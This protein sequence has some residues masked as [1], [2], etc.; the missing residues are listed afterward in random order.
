MSSALPTSVVGQKLPLR[1]QIRRLIDHEVPLRSQVGLGLGT[2][3]AHS[4]GMSTLRIGLGAALLLLGCTPINPAQNTFPQ[5]E[6]TQVAGPPGGQIDPGYGYQPPQ[7]QQDPVTYNAD[8][9]GYPQGYQQGYPDGSEAQPAEGYAPNGP[10]SVDQT[11]PAPSLEPSADPNDP[12]YDMGQVNDDEIDATLDG[13]G[14]WEESEDYGRVWVPDTTAVGVDFTPYETDGSWIWSD[15]GW[16]YQCD[17]SW[18]WLPF[19][20]GRW[21]WFDNHWGWQPG[22]QW[23]A[24]AVEWR[25]GGG[26]TGWRPLTPIIRDHRSGVNI[27]DHRTVT[28]SDSQWRFSANNEFGHGHI[29]GHLFQNPSEG[30]RVTNAVQRPNVRGNYAAVSSASLMRNR[31]SSN[32]ARNNQAMR[33]NNV[34]RPQ[35]GV[36]PQPQGFRSQG[37]TAPYRGTTPTWRAPAQQG[38]RAPAQQGYRPPAQQ[39]YRAP[40][41]QGYR[42]A[43]RPPAQQSWGNRGGYTQPSYNGASHSAPA[44]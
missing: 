12:G 15:A 19:H 22:N 1:E 44:R 7:Q 17:L 38:Y 43:Y 10:D 8:Q 5:P 28:A 24:G 26:Y 4:W 36:R 13:Y 14:Q 41:Q 2:I 16:N 23:S 40:A 9:P 21:G 27:R 30:L 35:P 25:G 32:F 37:T 11:T 34:A 39:G 29:K 3:A 18:G 33:G 31:L 42:P 6:P 20:Y